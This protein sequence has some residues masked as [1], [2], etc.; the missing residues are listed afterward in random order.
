LQF[1]EAGHDTR[2]T[3]L[4]EIVNHAREMAKS[5]LCP[6]GQSPILPLETLQIHFTETIAKE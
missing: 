6:L 5:S 1:P 4:E 3:I 2:I